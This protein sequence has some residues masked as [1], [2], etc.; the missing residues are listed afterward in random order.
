MGRLGSIEPSRRPRP[1]VAEHRERRARIRCQRASRASRHA[2]SARAAGRR[3]STS[4]STRYRSRRMLSADGPSSDGGS[5]RSYPN[6][7]SSMSATCISSCG[8]TRA[9]VSGLSSDAGRSRSASSGRAARRLGQAPDRRDRRLPRRPG[10]AGRRA[11]H[12]AA[13]DAA[14]ARGSAA[15]LDRR[16]EP[17][18]ANQRM[19]IA[20][21][22]PRA[23]SA[24]RYLVEPVA[25]APERPRVVRRQRALGQQHGFLDEIGRVRRRDHGRR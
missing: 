4:H 13:G 2:P 25:L 24:S 9:N 23:D 19:W 21:N 7:G 6:A 1:C 12:A 17:R 10:R 16:M 14:R 15:V 3:W 5:A 11:R 8:G 22:R 20:R 18:R